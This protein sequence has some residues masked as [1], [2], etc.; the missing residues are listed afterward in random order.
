MKV[1]WNWLGEFVDLTLP[2]EQLTE[3]L[4]M[5]G[6][7]VE[8]VEERGRQ[9]DGVRVAQVTSV[10][11]HPQADRLRICE[12]RTADLSA[13]VV[14]GAA[15]VASGQRVAYAPPGTRLPGGVVSTQEIRG[16]VSA[17][18]LCSEAELGLGPDDA[19]LLILPSN[20]PLG[21]RLGAYLKVEDMAI[22][23]SVT[24]NRGDCLSVIGLAR[25]IAALTGLHF[26]RPRVQVT[27]TIEGTTELVEIRIDDDQICGRYVGRLLTGVQIG[28]APLWMQYRLRAVGM[29]P[30]NNV[31]DVTNYV[32]IERGQ[33]LH[34]FDYDLLPEKQ[35]VVRR[36]GAPMHFRT[37][38]DQQRDIVADDLLITTGREVIAVAGI[39]G[40]G[41][42]EV[43][44]ST[45]RIL[46]ESAWFLPSSVRR[47]A[48]R[49]G[50]KT[51]ASYRFER[52]VDIEGVP[53]AA[54][55][56]AALI[57]Q[58]GAGTIASARIDVY[59]SARSPAPI[60][61]RLKRMEELLGMSI[62]RADVVAKLKTLGM[63]VAPAT[64]GTLTVVPP[65]FRTDLVREIDII[66]EVVRLVGYEN[67]PVT[68]PQCTIS[69]QGLEVNQRKK[70]EIKRFLSAQGLNEVVPLS[71]CSEELNRRFP[72]IRG[73]S[74][75]V[76][77]VNPLSPDER[78]LRLSLCSS[79]SRVARQ[80]LDQGNHEVAIFTIGKVFWRGDQTYCEARH[81]G[82]LVCPSIAA[83]GLLKIEPADFGDV[84]G[85]VEGLFERLF[86]GKVRWERG[87]I[88]AAFHPGLSAQ[89]R[90]EQS[91]VG[92][93]GA[94]HPSANDELG[95]RSPCWL[96]E[97]DL[98]KVLQY[99]PPRIVF[100]ELPRF[101]A[102]IRDLAILTDDQFAADEVARFVRAWSD[103][104][105]L[106]EEV[107]LFDEY[108]GEPIPAGQK[109]LAYSIAYRASDRTL[110]DA[111]VNEL[112]ERL[113]AALTRDLKVQPR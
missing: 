103:G 20:A 41:N 74:Q 63:N 93:L 50:L 15:N 60:A 91:E 92:V 17:G 21:D 55:R 33:P 22:D 46:L 23:V 49:L 43:N 52:S 58:M 45:K 77:I 109:S 24:P 105:G 64:R 57:A 69:G 37:L 12:I 36:A 66:E 27:E 7:E 86:V 44:P 31:V 18:M 11:P 112:H 80:N 79:L 96:F 87:A 19:G 13:S 95:L 106:I 100:Q 72:G 48:K 75:A 1:T 4:D 99:C 2:L 111:E 65:S 85:I 38:D 62:P 59:P 26:H 30:I 90:I 102:V 68:L 67:V 10:A 53:A 73:D 88:G 98:D 25:E 94:L 47:T 76:S 5:A 3:R 82:G 101:P 110:T 34:A 81:L 113:K 61:L 89:I 39:M 29:R 84:K 56:A 16:V 108:S 14:C 9:V 40:G 28:A 6:L 78:A 35:I 54:D 51:E 71:F 107:H 8:S 42:S 104:N 32:M 70:R 97:L 83:R